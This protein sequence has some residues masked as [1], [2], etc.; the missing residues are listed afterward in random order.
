[1]NETQRLIKQPNLGHPSFSKNGNVTLTK[2][3]HVWSFNDWS[4]EFKVEYDVIVNKE[5]PGSWKSL[6]H[7]TTG[8]DLGV[9]GRIPAAFVNPDKYFFCYHVNGDDDYCQSYNYELNKDYHFE[10]CQYKNSK[11]EA[12]YNIKVN[13]KTFF[14]I[15][16]DYA[17]HVMLSDQMGQ[18]GIV[19]MESEG[20]EV[21]DLITVDKTRIFKEMCFKDTKIEILEKTIASTDAVKN[22]IDAGRI[23]FAADTLGASESMIEK[24]VA[25]SKERKQFNIFVCSNPS[26][27]NAL[28]I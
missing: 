6:F 14:V 21:I 28:H 5:L 17:T 1:M 15:D 10:I 4:N 8:E 9:G 13:G 2:D 23:I 20:I 26:K 22:A 3:N 7:L 18:I 27:C 25:Y 16:S 24:A 19:S 11:G 12:I